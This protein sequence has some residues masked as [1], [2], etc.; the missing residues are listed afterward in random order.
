LR[1]LP[2]VFLTPHMAGPTLDHYSDL[3]LFAL[4][5]VACYF[6]GEPLQAVIDGYRY[7]HQT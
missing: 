7:D 5:N 4:R 6:N 3:G 2:N 1:G